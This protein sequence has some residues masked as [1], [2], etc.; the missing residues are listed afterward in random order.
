MLA[1]L[2][3]GLPIAA[4]LGLGGCVLPAGSE[5]LRLFESSLRL[6]EAAQPGAETTTTSWFVPSRV[7]LGNRML[8]ISGRLEV[9]P[10][11]PAPPRQVIVRVR[12]LNA[13]TG[14]VR[15]R[16]RLVVE[17]SPENGFRESKKFPKI[18]AGESLV[19]VSVEPV[20]RELVEGAEVSLCIDVAR[21]RGELERFASCA[22]G[23]AASTLSG[24]QVSV[25]S[26]SCAVSGCHD[27]VTAERGLVLESGES[28]AN[29][30]GVLATQSPAELRVRP[31]DPDR[32]YLIKKLRGTNNIGG[33][34]PLGGPFLTEEEIAGVAE[35]IE[36]GARDN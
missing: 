25:F 11:G 31:G 17:R 36:N 2:A 4:L 14:K 28:F 10:E 29:L 16:Y 18:V 35:W 6:A 20:G 12:I 32:S 21:K 15:K 24:I 13:A 19:T 33:R 23:D 34:M 27:R 5:P 9:D 22:V 7:K 26:G 1:R 3:Q 30:V 8:Q